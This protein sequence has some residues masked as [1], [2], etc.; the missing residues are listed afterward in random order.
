MK[1]HSEKQPIDDLFA[2]KLGDMSLKPSSDG[3]ERLQAR[4]NQNKSEVRV[5]FWRNPVVQR[6]MAIAACLLLVCLFGWLYQTKN[7]GEEIGD[8][9]ASNQTRQSKAKQQDSKG[10]IYSKPIEDGTSE[11]GDIKSVTPA[12]VEE[13]LNQEELAYSTG[14]N[15]IGKS[16]SK[17]LPV[18]NQ[19]EKKPALGTDEAIE[20][21]V[22]AQ[23]KPT[24]N[25]LKTEA[26]AVA[27]TIP[28]TPVERLA[29]NTTKPAI[30]SERVLVVTIG[31]PESLVAARQVVKEAALE[32]SV[33]AAND[34]PESEGKSGGLW[35]QVKRIK[36]GEIFARRDNNSS[37]DERGLLGRA[38]NGLKHNLDK[39]KSVK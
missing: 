37:D 18:N 13:K 3:F 8:R 27:N 14:R 1:D 9:V 2:R 17:T 5:V 25:L 19:P 35:Q 16:P 30:P 36:Q 12:T 11:Q 20:K 31:E 10:Q 33:A 34:K 28:A 26:P 32:K 39:D 4:M 38:Y 29:D 23:T 6:Y 21:A 15:A 22:L 7:V 24:D